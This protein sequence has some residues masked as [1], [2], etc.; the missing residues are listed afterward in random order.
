MMLEVEPD[1]IAAQK[2]YEKLGYQRNSKW[3]MTIADRPFGSYQRRSDL[4]AYSKALQLKEGFPSDNMKIQ[5]VLSS[6][7][8]IPNIDE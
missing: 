1:N 6:F 2:L 5:Q 3:F 7:L 8:R 4:I